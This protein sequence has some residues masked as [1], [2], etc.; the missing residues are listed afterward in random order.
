VTRSLL[1]TTSFPPTRGGLETLLYQ[2]SRRLE[3]PPL[4]LAPSPAGVSDLAVRQ[5]P[6]G[7]LGRM[8]YRGLWRV[9]PSLH[10]L[11]TFWRPAARAMRDWRP[12]VVQVGHVALAPLGLVLAR[13]AGRGVVIYAY[14]QELLA[15]T[16]QHTRERRLGTG[17][18]RSSNLLRVD[19]RLDD[20]AERVDQ[21][22]RG[23][24]LRA[25]DAV[26][27]PGSFTA[28]LVAG[29]EVAAERIVQIPFGAEP[30]P[31]G[32]P[33]QGTS[34]LSVG[35]LVPRKGI[36]TVL[37]AL[38][39]LPESVTYR[40]VG[41]GP[42]EP[43]LRRLAQNL[44]LHAR[45]QFLGNLSGAALAEEYQRCVLF[46]LPSRRT[47]D[48]ELEGLGLVFFEAAAWGRPVLAGRSG[49]EVDAVVDGETGLLV[50]GESVEQVAAAIDTLLNDPERLRRLGDQGRKRVETTHN[51]QRAAA[52]VDEVLRG[53]AS[54]VS[55]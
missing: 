17:R 49:G 5:V 13:R 47:P 48:G 54:R 29:W 15:R 30:R 45:V 32:P 50:D 19:S 33:P 44:N 39:M 28:G 31:A 18:T 37:R 26:L 46:V 53:V 20:V 6:T 41:D 24:P 34:L 22:L 11:S 36:D 38:P 1:L 9:H 35:R 7:L 14:G 42:D 4:V 16:N 25:A 21:R 10:Y 55:P 3:D 23:G 40:I 51:W 27:V 12:R 8:V 43:R 52:S 2:T